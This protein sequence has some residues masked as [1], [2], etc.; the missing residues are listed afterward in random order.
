MKY[1]VAQYAVDAF[2]SYLLPEGAEV[3]LLSDR[4]KEYAVRISIPDVIDIVLRDETLSPNNL[5]EYL[6]KLREE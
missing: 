3:F 4:P 5:L 6:S 2:R 1:S